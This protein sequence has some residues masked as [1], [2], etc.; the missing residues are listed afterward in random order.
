[1]VMI[2]WAAVA[3]ENGSLPIVIKWLESQSKILRDFI[4]ID[5]SVLP[6]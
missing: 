6:L 5:N 1:M 3:P 2:N 4:L